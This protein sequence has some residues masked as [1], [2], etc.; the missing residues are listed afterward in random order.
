MKIFAVDQHISVV[1][2]LRKIFT[3]LGHT[4]TDWCL[5][6]HADIMGRK[7]DSVPMLDGDRWCGFVQREGWNEFYD[8]YKRELDKYDAFLCCYPPLFAMLYKRFNKPVIFHIPIRYEYPCQS[9]A[10]DWSQWNEYLC[11][12][13]DE[14]QFHIAANSLYDAKYFET[15]VSRKCQW[16]PSLCEYT[17]ARYDPRVSTWLYY[18][19]AAVPE[20]RPGFVRKH[21]VLNHGHSWNSLGW[22]SGIL[23]I[24]Y[25]VST[26]SMFEQYA[27]GIPIAVPTLDFAM[28]LYESREVRIFEQITWAGTFGREPGSVVPYGAKYDPNAFRTMDAV[29]W[30]MQ[31]ADYYHKD[32]LREVERFGSWEEARELFSAP[33]SRI[34][35][36]RNRIKN[37][38]NRR[39]EIA[40][41]SW[42][43][44][45][46]GVQV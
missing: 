8:T 23:H 18:A 32:A 16:I 17:G 24:P 4:I 40:Y 44:M 10:D 1:A 21:K 38:N 45:L 26:M 41:S 2:D 22:F 35:D 15:F 31:Y 9:S 27:A 11:A 5:S 29:R 7:R 39:R 30:W 37:D 20:L 34:I 33:R 43:K 3:D 6:G 14:G 36:M 28:K 46:A 13:I 42:E 19:P 25:N 12:G